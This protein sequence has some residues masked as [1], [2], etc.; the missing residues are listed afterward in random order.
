MYISR[1][2]EYAV[3]I[4]ADLASK[5][6]HPVLQQELGKGANF[7]AEYLTGE[8]ENLKRT[9]YVEETAS[10]LHLRHKPREINIGRLVRD[11]SPELG[12]ELP[13]TPDNLYKAPPSQAFNGLFAGAVSAYLSSLDNYTLQDLVPDIGEAG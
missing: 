3:R 4:L 6:P 2:T 10:G 13:L 8:I 5:S 1:S 12:R 7:T 11:L 9:G